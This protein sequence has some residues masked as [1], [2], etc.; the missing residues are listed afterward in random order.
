MTN[1]EKLAQI[2]NDELAQIIVDNMCKMCVFEYASIGCRNYSCKEDIL[3]W[4]E[5]EVEELLI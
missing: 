5:S 3:E 2:T 4:L 1:R